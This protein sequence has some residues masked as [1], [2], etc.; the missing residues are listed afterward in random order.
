MKKLVSSGS[1][2][3]EPIGFS[4]ACRI[5]NQV[6]VSGT[7]PILDGKAAYIGN[8]YGQMKLCLDIAVTA[9]K[10]AGGNLSDVIRTR[11]MLVDIK[12]WEEAARAHGELFSNIRPACTFVEVKG[13]I[14]PDW[15]VEIEMD[16]VVFGVS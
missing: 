3:E 15:L 4:R 14:D 5:G 6:A 12:C 8:V 7:A 16:T 11:I 2:L 9:L 10:E 13:F 1:Y